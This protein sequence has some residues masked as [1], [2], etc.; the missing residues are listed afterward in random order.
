MLLGGATVKVHVTA[1]L[2]AARNADPTP[3]PDRIVGDVL[4]RLGGEARAGL[5]GVL[6]GTGIL[7]H[8]NLGR[9]PLARE[10]LDAIAD[11]TGGAN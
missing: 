6:N 10:A 1:A 2:A 3:A 5:A 4:A 7:L 11:T 8:T 9:A